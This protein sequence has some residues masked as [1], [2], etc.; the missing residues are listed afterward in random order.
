MKLLNLETSMIDRA[1]TE[2]VSEGIPPAPCGPTIMR[3]DDALKKKVRNLRVSTV[4]KRRHGGVV[5][6]GS[7][8]AHT[9]GRAVETS[10]P[11]GQDGFQSCATLP[12]IICGQRNV[13]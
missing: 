4:R 3:N 9:D 13:L 5:A 10:V 12:Y 8:Y 2:H 11:R 6:G 7:G 1:Y